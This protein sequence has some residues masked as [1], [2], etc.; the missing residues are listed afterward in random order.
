[1]VL[2]ELTLQIQSGTSLRSGKALQDFPV[3]LFPL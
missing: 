2:E 3:A 1:M